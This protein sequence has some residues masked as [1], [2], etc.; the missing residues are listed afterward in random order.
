MKP[1]VAVNAVYKGELVNCSRDSYPSIRTALQQ[2]AGKWIDQGD[3]L[4]AQMALMEVQRLDE[5][6]NFDLE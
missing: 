6:H 4:R 5:V 2:Q 1:E 3:H